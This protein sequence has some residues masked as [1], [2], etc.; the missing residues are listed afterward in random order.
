MHQGIEMFMFIKPRGKGHLQ[1]TS[2]EKFLKTELSI[3]NW[4]Q[5]SSGILLKL[6]ETILPGNKTLADCL[7]AALRSE[8]KPNYLIA[9]LYLLTLS[10]LLPCPLLPWKQQ[11]SFGK[12]HCSFI[13]LVFSFVI[14]NRSHK[15]VFKAG[16]QPPG[17]FMKSQDI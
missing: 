9:A 14:V 12:C 6:G 8:N 16:H 4:L 7:C 11:S 5:I 15:V 13:K 1:S 3:R 10:F 2:I 17:N